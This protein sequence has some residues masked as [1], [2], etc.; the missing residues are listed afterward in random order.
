MKIA[1]HA[2]GFVMDGVYSQARGEQRWAMNLAHHLGL[3]GHDIFLIA[4]KFYYNNDLIRPRWGQC[5]E[6]KNVEICTWGDEQLE[7]NF[8]IFMDTGWNK[9][10]DDSR[11]L[12]IKSEI[13]L[14]CFWGIDEQIK[15]PKGLVQT[16][17]RHFYA[18]PTKRIVEIEDEQKREYDTSKRLFL[19]IPLYDQ[20][21]ERENDNLITWPLKECFYK[22]RGDSSR[23]SKILLK[24]I[25]EITDNNPDVEVFFIG[26][27]E[28]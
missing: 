16:N 9:G 19:P 13:Y 2:P 26:T 22:D 10:I 6:S 25:K 1:I 24:T 3:A 15:D 17:R 14:W 4:D 12:S 8:D 28:F 7:G 11:N 21:V 5:P 20:W 27:N 18:Y 23:R